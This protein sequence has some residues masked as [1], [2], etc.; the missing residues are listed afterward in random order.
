[1]LYEKKG[2]SRRVSPESVTLSSHKPDHR[3]LNVPR[4][5]IQERSELVFWDFLEYKL[6]AS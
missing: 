5:E 4:F 1:M 3:C 6:E 2:K